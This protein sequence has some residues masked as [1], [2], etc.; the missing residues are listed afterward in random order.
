MSVLRRLT[1]TI[2]AAILGLFLL[3]WPFSQAGLSGVIE[4]PS[5]RWQLA[6]ADGNLLFVSGPP[7]KST[8]LDRDHYYISGA[9]N[10]GFYSATLWPR[11][12]R[13]PGLF[14]LA[15]PLLP[16][17]LAAIHILILANAPALVLTRRRRARAR[18][19]ACGYGRIGDGECQE[20]GLLPAQAAART[21]PQ[22][23]RVLRDAAW[24]IFSV[25]ALL[26]CGAWL[27]ARADR[28]CA[29]VSR[30]D[31]FDY[32]WY[33][34]QCTPHL[35][36]S[37]AYA[38]PGDGADSLPI[39]LRTCPPGTTIVLLPGVHDLGGGSAQPTSATALR[40]M[41]LIG[42]GR[43][44]TT[45]TL[46]L[47]N[48]DRLR[49]ENLTIDCHN[50]P[51]ADIR[52][53]AT[54]HLRNCLIKN[55]NSGGGGS[56]ALELA[57]SVALIEQCEFEGK[58]GRASSQA[59][60]TAI[61]PRVDTR[62][63][64]R[65]TTFTN[66]QEV[67]RYA[68][69]VLDACTATTDRPQWFSPPTGDHLLR[70]NV[71]MP[72]GPGSPLPGP[73]FTESLDDLAPLQALGRGKGARAW[74]DPFARDQAR[75][76]DLSGNRQFWARLLLHADPQVRA[77]AR[78]HAAPPALDPPLTSDEALQQLTKWPIPARAALSLLAQPDTSRSALE[79][80]RT[81]GA[82]HAQSNAAALLQLMSAQ[83]PLPEI[84]AAQSINKT[85]ADK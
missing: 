5:G 81:T 34:D 51:F 79:S 71:N 46:H 19:L 18:C 16:F 50:D 85:A 35:T 24:T 77:L 13:A 33:L 54:L 36:G 63:F 42:C 21:S 29:A 20:C 78:T 3:A 68:S 25:L 31:T 32:S 82:S 47:Y 49:L 15:I 55:Y 84:V 4:R 72:T 74:T 69:G 65:N 1:S 11:V 53:G 30:A 27:L 48:A 58:T 66:N 59:R 52:A 37:V 17:A 61:D 8:P 26:S 12:H 73:T 57:S 44:D 6:L 23:R 9:G 45:L 7:S 43:A 83:P 22:A 39:L 80:I 67:F 70:R 41:W 62:L 28:H 2:A 14:I 76:L 64:I 40:D 56:T 10:I 38:A 75:A 60:G